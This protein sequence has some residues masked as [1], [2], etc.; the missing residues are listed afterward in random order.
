[1]LAAQLQ[2]VKPEISKG[3][4]IVIRPGGRLRPTLVRYSP[5]LEQLQVIEAAKFGFAGPRYLDVDD[6]ARPVVSDQDAH[7]V[8][9]INPDI[10]DL[11]GSMG[12]GMPGP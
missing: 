7:R 11:L 1:M 8:L 6:F 12:D 5:E 3:D 2:S 4:G 9:L 10:G